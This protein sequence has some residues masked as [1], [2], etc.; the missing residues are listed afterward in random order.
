MTSAIFYD[1]EK[2]PE[3]WTLLSTVDESESYETDI[4]EIW[5]TQ[6]GYA[7][8]T[9]SGCSCWG[10]EYDTAEFDSIELLAVALL[11]EDRT[12]NPS[13]RGALDLLTDAV[14]AERVKK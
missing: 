2:T 1:T 7:L 8:L 14:A 12:Y 6:K 4:A 11:K 13:T 3:G 9:A 10:G 5:K